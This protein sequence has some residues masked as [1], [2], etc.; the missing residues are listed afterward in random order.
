MAGVTDGRNW[1]LIH[2][3]IWRCWNRRA[4]LWIR[5]RP[6]AGWQL[7]EEFLELRRQ[8]EARLGKRGRREYVQVL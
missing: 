2:C 4:T 1:Y 3:I 5:L 8:M 7:P 6:L